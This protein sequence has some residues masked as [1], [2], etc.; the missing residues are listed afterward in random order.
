MVQRCLSLIGRWWQRQQWLKTRFI[1]A[2]LV[3]VDLEL[4]GLDAK[5]HEIVSAAWLPISQGQ[6][7]LSGAKHIINR[8]VKALEQSPVFHGLCQSHIDTGLPLDLFTTKLAAAIEDKVVVFHHSH[9]DMAFIRHLFLQQGMRSRP[10]L[11]VDTL[12]LER[13][14]LLVKGQEIGQDD[15]TLEESRKRYGLPQYSGHHAL[16]D[17]LA[18]GELL[19]AQAHQIGGLNQLKL[20]ELV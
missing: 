4:T 16:T 18:T 13:R 3:V 17:A 10:R 7:H 14:R 20:A 12:Q 11:I 5:Q 9:L 19:L 1:D 15:L 2:D 6:I 8:D